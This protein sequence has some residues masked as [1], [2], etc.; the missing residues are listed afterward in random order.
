V[1]AAAASLD[2]TA[3]FVKAFGSAAPPPFPERL[4]FPKTT[5]H[6]RYPD[7]SVVDAIK[8]VVYDW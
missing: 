1:E 5:Y 4:G 6:A 2:A 7:Q 3:A 8:N